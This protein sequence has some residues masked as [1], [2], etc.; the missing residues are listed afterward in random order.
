MT[1]TNAREI[2]CHLVYEMYLNDVTAAEALTA[3]MDEG[4]YP[5]LKSE[6]DVYEEKAD[7]QAAGISAERRAGRAGEARRAGRDISSSTPS[8]GAWGA[9]RRWP[10]R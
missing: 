9:S 6:S 2:A 8:A 4:Y 5:S 7:G 1:R 10:V 3:L